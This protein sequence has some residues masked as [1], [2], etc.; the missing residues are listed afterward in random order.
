MYKLQGLGLGVGYNYVGAAGEK[1]KDKDFIVSIFYCSFNTYLNIYNNITTMGRGRTGITNQSTKKLVPRRPH[2]IAM[3]LGISDKSNK[4]KINLPK[5]A[6]EF[7]KNM[8]KQQLVDFLL[9]NED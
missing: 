7:M 9:S 5:D 3:F 6:L 1:K 4:T 2:N 8:N